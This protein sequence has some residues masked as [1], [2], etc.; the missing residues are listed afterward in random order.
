MPD[1]NPGLVRV[2]VVDG[3]SGI[4]RDALPDLFNEF[5]RA[6]NAWATEEAG[7]DTVVF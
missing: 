4:P 5:Y 3:G 1:R 7:T 6:S 2:H